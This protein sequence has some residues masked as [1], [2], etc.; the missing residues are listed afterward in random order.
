MVNIL[1][2][3]SSTPS[4]LWS[5]LRQHGKCWRSTLRQ[6]R[7]HFVNTESVDGQHFVNTVNTSSTRK[8]LTVNTS[9]TRKV[10]TIVRIFV[11]EENYLPFLWLTSWYYGVIVKVMLST[12]HRHL[13]VL[14]MGFTELVSAMILMWVNNW[15]FSITRSLDGLAKCTSMGSNSYFSL[16]LIWVFIR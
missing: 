10:L 4:T 13:I 2:N 1:V 14:S 12:V 5:T 15:S 3:T 7:Q 6:H 11:K 16:L 8:V 9:S